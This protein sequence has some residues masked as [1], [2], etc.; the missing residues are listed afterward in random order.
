[1]SA[2]R[3]VICCTARPYWLPCQYTP[4]QERIGV[5]LRPMQA[6]GKGPAYRCC[7]NLAAQ[8]GDTLWPSPGSS[9]SR[10]LL[11]RQ[12]SMRHSQTPASHLPLAC[13]PPHPHRS[14]PTCSERTPKTLHAVAGCQAARRAPQAAA[15][16]GVAQAGTRH[17]SGH[18]CSVRKRQG[19]AGR[20]RVLLPG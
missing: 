11:S 16:P 8:L 14:L 19:G 13:A 10:L 12:V 4:L 20:Q 15:P 2:I 5:A 6:S 17:C 18:N 1:M 7:L 9:G 3:S